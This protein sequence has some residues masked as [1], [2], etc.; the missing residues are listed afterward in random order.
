MP[1][2]I[3]TSFGF[4]SIS[5]EM[6]LQ[7]LI[8][9]CLPSLTSPMLSS[10]LSPKNNVF[11]PLLTVHEE[12]LNEFLLTF[13]KCLIKFILHLDLSLYH[14]LRY[15]SKTL[16]SITL[17]ISNTT[18]VIIHI[19]PKQKFFSAFAYNPWRKISM[20]FLLI[21]T[22]CLTKFILHLDLPTKKKKKLFCNHLCLNYSSNFSQS[23]QVTKN[24]TLAINN[25]MM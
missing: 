22:K 21:F 9:Y 3:H 2:Q 10:T 5:S 19:V 12:N 4:I 1:H 16:S 18:N 15:N 25:K 13:T 14:H 20:Q 24:Q 8:S 11:W 23:K 6:Q 7:S 17:F